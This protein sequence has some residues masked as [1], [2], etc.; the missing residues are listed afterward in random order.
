ML[1]CVFVRLFTENGFQSSLFLLGE[2]GFGLS[3]ALS[4]RLYQKQDANGQ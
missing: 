2:S 4:N 3:G 1:S